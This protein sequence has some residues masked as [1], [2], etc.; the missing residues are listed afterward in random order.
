MDIRAVA[1]RENEFAI[2]PVRNGIKTNGFARKGSQLI[3]R[4]ENVRAEA[5]IKDPFGDIR[6]G[7]YVVNPY[8]AAAIHNTQQISDSMMLG[9]KESARSSRH[10]AGAVLNIPDSNRALIAGRNE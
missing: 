9:I 2:Y 8:F 5:A 6:T 1:R 7:V 3:A 10:K 4:R